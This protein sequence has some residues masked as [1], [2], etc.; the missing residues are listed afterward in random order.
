MFSLKLRCPASN[1]LRYSKIGARTPCVC[2]FI[3]SSHNVAS[4]YEIENKFIP[5]ASS[6]RL[7]KNNSGDPPFHTLKELVPTAFE[8]TYYDDDD[9][10]CKQGIWLRYRRNV[11]SRHRPHNRYQPRPESEQFQGWELKVRQ[12]GTHAPSI[13]EEIRDESRIWSIVQ[14]HLPFAGSVS[15]VGG[16]PYENPFQFWDN[17]VSSFMSH[18]MVPGL[19]PTAQFK[20]KRRTWIAQEHDEVEH[21]KIMIDETDFGHRVGEVEITTTAGPSDQTLTGT[22]TD[23]DATLRETQERLDGFMNRYAWA[24]PARGEQVVGKLGAYF[25]QK[26]KGVPI[27]ESE[28]RGN[29]SKERSL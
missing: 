9:I 22:P 14:E 5:S 15:D 19:D 2:H 17:D 11:L 4:E 24:F 27:M 16:T 6:I 21:Y 23:R 12:S 13:F 3:R 28:A 10:L 26:G 8:D 25:E 7:L 18:F 1:S 20:T 29:M